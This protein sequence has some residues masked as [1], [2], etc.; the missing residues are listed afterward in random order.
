[1]E[2]NKLDCSSV[3]TA[4]LG[5]GTAVEIFNGKYQSGLWF[6]M[7]SNI[8]LG[9]CGRDTWWEITNR[10]AVQYVQQY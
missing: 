10:T 9:D 2:N 3:C 4:I 1:M 6:S 7:Y 8:R 5:Y